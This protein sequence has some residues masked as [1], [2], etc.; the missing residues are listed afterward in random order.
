MQLRVPGPRGPVIKQRRR[1]TCG[2]DLVDAV[3]AAPRHRRTAVQEPE[4][5]PDGGGVRGIN[6]G[7][8]GRVTQGPQSADRLGCGERQVVPGHR[9]HPPPLPQRAPGGRGQGPAEHGLQLLLL[10]HR[11]GGEAQLAQALAVPTTGA[12]T[13][14]AVVLARTPGDGPLVVPPRRTADLRRRQHQTTPPG[15][16]LQDNNFPAQGNHHRCTCL[17]RFRSGGCR[18]TR[19]MTG[20]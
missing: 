9:I 11:T 6:R 14:L 20:R 17:I 3:L 1:Q 18:E 2:P 4:R 8:G 19:P 16:L 10:N 7:H 13:V 12:V 5:G 15:I